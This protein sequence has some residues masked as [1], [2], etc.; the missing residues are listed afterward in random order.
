[1]AAAPRVSTVNIKKFNPK[2]IGDNR[3]CVFIGKRGTGK[4]T[5]VTDILYHK[6]HIPVGICMSGT[7]EGNCYYQDYI[8]DLFVYNEYKSDV[9]E[10]VIERQKKLVRT[11]KPNTHA[12]CLID[13]C[14]YD[15]KMIRDPRIRG[16]FMNGRHWNLFFMLT[17][18]YCMDLSPDLRANIDYVF[19]LR[20]N[21]IQNRE[22][23]FKNFFGIFPNYEMFSQV[24][25]SC[26]ENFECLVLDNTSRSNSIEDVVFW[27][28]ANLRPPGTFRI[29][30]PQFWNCHRAKYNP[31]YEDAVPE[32]QIQI[33][34]K[35]PLT[36]KKGK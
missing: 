22:K 35:N 21:I 19:V 28:K 18:Q 34:T 31:K 3:V 27:Y 17:M 15:K 36:I 11:K 5:L 1:M 7:E 6:R 30:S 20:E 33:K 10:K 4:T 25:N 29:G 32:T 24:L 26:T 23:I 2:S 14:M 16:V 8:P 13:D 12:F 9:L